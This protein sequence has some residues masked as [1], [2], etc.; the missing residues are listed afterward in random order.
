MPRRIPKNLAIL[1]TL[2]FIL[3]QTMAGAALAV[4][5]LHSTG[6][7]DTTV[8]LGWTHDTAEQ[9]T[10]LLY[11]PAG[12]NSWSSANTTGPLL[13]DSISATVYGLSPNTAYDFKV[14]TTAGQSVASNVY[15]NSGGGDTDPPTWPGGSLGNSSLTST[16]LTLNWPMAND[17]VGVFEYIIL[18]NNVFL[19][20]VAGNVY[21]YNVT[22]LTANT[23]Y[24]FKV[25]AL[26]EAYNESVPLS[27]DVLTPSEGGGGGGGGGGPTLPSPV[28]RYDSVGSPPGDPGMYHPFDYSPNDGLTLYW[29]EVQD[30]VSPVPTYKIYRALDSSAN[31]NDPAVWGTPIAVITSSDYNII[32]VNDKNVIAYNHPLLLDGTDSGREYRYAVKAEN[33]GNVSGISNIPY[34]F[35]IPGESLLGIAWFMLKSDEFTT[36]KYSLRIFFTGP[37]DYSKAVTVANYNVTIDGSPVTLKG[38]DNYKA[39]FDSV[40]NAVIMDTN[41]STSV[42]G[43]PEIIITASNITGPAP[44]NIPMNNDP[45]QGPYNVFSGYKSEHLAGGGAGEADGG[46]VPMNP[47][48]GQS[49][50]YIFHF[51]AKENIPSGGK[52]LITFPSDY[53]ISNTIAMAD[54]SGRSFDPN[55]DI[56][57]GD[58]GTVTVTAVSVNTA[59]RQVELTLSGS[60]AAQDEVVFA[61]SNINNP[62][63]ASDPGQAYLINVKAPS[64][65]ANTLILPAFVKKAG[66]ASLTVNLIDKDNNLPIALDATV[67]IGGPGL[68]PEGLSKTNSTGTFTFT[69]LQ[70]DSGYH[71]WLSKPPAGFKTPIEVMPV[72]PGVAVNFYLNN[73]GAAYMKTLTVTVENLPDQAKAEVFADSGYYFD[74]T[75]VSTPA[76][77]ST[78]VYT[79]KV[80]APGEYMVGVRPYVPPLSTGMSTELPPPEFMPLPPRPYMVTG[81]MAVSISLPSQADLAPVIVELK[82]EGGNVPANGGVYAYSPTNPEV[83]GTGGLINATTGQVTLKLKKGVSY[84]VGGGAPG[85]PPVP[86]KKVF[87]NSSGNAVIDGSQVAMVQLRVNKPNKRITGY[88]KYSDGSAVSKVPVSAHQNNAPGGTPPSFTD[89]SGSYTLFVGSGSWTVEAFIPEVGH[90]VITTNADTTTSEVVTANLTLPALTSFATVTGTV[91]EGGNPVAGAMIWAQASNKEFLNG[92]ITGPDGRYTLKVDSSKT[93]GAT[94]HCSAP[95]IGDLEPVTFAATVNFTVTPAALTINFGRPVSGYA[96]VFQAGVQGFHNGKKLNDVNSVELKA[97]A[98][99]YT[100][101]CFIEGIGRIVRDNV[102]VPGTLNLTSEASVA[103]TVNLNVVVAGGGNDTWVNVMGIQQGKTVSAGKYTSG[104]SAS[105]T[106]PQN[107]EVTVSVRKEGYFHAKQ[108]VTTGTADSTVNITLT[109][110]NTGTAVTVNLTGSGASAGNSEYLV[111]AKNV[112]S[113]FV[114]KTSSANPTGISMKLPST[115]NWVF[116]AS[117]Q[118][119]SSNESTVNIAEPATVS[120]ALDNVTLVRTATAVVKPAQGG[121]VSNVSVG[122]QMVIPANALG[123]DNT[124]ASVN[125]ST[126]N[127]VSETSTAKPMGSA[128]DITITDSQGNPIT[129]LNQSIEI[130]LDY[131]SDYLTWPADQRDAMAQNMQMAYWDSAVDDWVTIPATND[132]VLHTLRGYTDHLTKFAVVYPQTLVLRGM[133]TQSSQSSNPGVDRVSIAYMVSDSSL[134][135]AME[136]AKSSGK[137]TLQSTSSDG[138]LG[139]TMEQVNKVEAAAKPME[140]KISDVTFNLSASA[141]KA[142]DL[143]LDSVGSFALGARKVAESASKELASKA[144][145]RD[146]YRIM[147]DIYLF[148]ATAKMQDNTEKDIKQF[149][150]K[151][152]VYLP[153]STAGKEA[154]AKGNLFASRFNEATGEWDV[155]TG[156]YEASSGMYRFETDRFSNWG[157]VEKVLLPL[158]TFTDISGHWAQKDIEHMATYGYISGMGQGLYAP[159]SSVTRAQFATMLVNV[160]KLDGKVDVPFGDFAPGQWYYFTVGRAYAAGL[161]KG[162]GP[163]RFAPEELITREQMA[164]MICNAL[165][166]KALLADVGNV[167]EV[168]KAFADQPSISGWARKSSAQAVKHGILR[169]KPWGGQVIFAPADKATRAEAAVMLKNLVGQFK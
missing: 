165:K 57:G 153:V 52:I 11:S 134:D 63:P 67:N 116:K 26:D 158:K 119:Y 72:W 85:M 87:V 86:E 101:E 109:P 108:D 33:G 46:V 156:S 65:S 112:A 135:N 125:A 23:T 129:S 7:T 155:V 150:G 152:T 44:G 126:T 35:R 127:A 42:T 84:I 12:L 28:W 43:D 162:I 95:G 91:T 3:T 20:S 40:K 18:K 105:F 4:T 160:L 55:A 102:S 138:K 168:L 88:I 131:H 62:T 97:P 73:T 146:K 144:K 103:N 71:V 41:I 113:G 141:L 117:T 100:I 98:G 8:S 167:E 70:P 36:G 68:P 47:L 64:T 132:T 74:K 13:I 30:G 75:V 49:S 154:A 2:V 149:N 133:E 143:S 1:L 66:S 78:R 83:M 163:D 50:E 32:T 115:G 89:D 130:V 53:T 17:N 19:D 16:S 10:G 128:R 5:G 110:Q 22:G 37:V 111:W 157:L 90:Q 161:V 169:G 24:N 104:G 123:S 166:Y 76:T 54:T 25:K 106:L 51:V 122:V 58:G 81:N 164:D 6:V 147:G 82:D 39:F 148:I 121:T 96:K 69:A 15:T 9:N 118:G 56:N 45:Q 48:G 136:T 120:M 77:G 60:V 159:D 137:V 139:L 59:T 61:L 29:E 124:N 14:I 145:N 94:V 92:T 79:L 114:V 80:A 142:A 34:P 31:W 21:S 38:P 27:M 93:S 99:T 151:V 107:V 140:V